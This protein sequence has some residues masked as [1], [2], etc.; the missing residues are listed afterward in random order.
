METKSH[1]NEVLEKI[2]KLDSNHTFLAVII[3][4]SSLKKDDSYYPKVFLKSTNILKKVVE[5]MDDSL[6]DFSYSS[7][8]CDE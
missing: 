3:L 6:S 8:K 2:P 4:N 1:G 5:H 7:D